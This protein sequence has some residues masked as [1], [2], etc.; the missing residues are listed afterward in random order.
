LRGLDAELQADARVGGTVAEPAVTG[1]F[2]LV[3]GRLDLLGKTFDFR[4]A[5]VTFEGRDLT[6]R[7]AVAAEARSREVTAVVRVTGTATRPEIALTSVPDLPQEEV[8]ARLLFEKSPSQLSAFE[9]AQLA[10]SVAQLAGIGGGPG[11]VDTLRRSFG[12]DRLEIDGGS[13]T[14]AGDGGTSGGV[15]AGRYVNDRV[16]VGVEQRFTG[17]SRA[18]VEVEI[19]DNIRVESTVGPQTGTGVGVNFRWDY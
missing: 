2:S 5:D 3:R 6:P 8:L 13:G 10:Q 1:G 12:L 19:T 4:Q 16:Y 11:V 15:S 14:G 9:A 17:E 7:L 18:R